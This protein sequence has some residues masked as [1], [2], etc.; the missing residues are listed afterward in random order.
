MGAAAAVENEDSDQ[1]GEERKLLLDP[2]ILPKP[3]VE[4]NPTLTA[5]LQLTQMSRPCSP[6]LPRQLAT[7]LMCLP[8]TPRAR[9]STR[10]DRASSVPARPCS[11]AG[12]PIGRS[13]HR[14]H[15]SPAS[16]TKWWPASQI[17]RRAAS[18][19]VYFLRSV[20]TSKSEDGPE[21]A[22]TDRHWPSSSG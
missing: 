16:P 5:Y 19:S 6:S 20:W 9:S 22:R 21:E 15:L 12:L 7:S 2:G 3:P 14:C 13:C 17:S 18:A 11:A 1:D 8:Q 10:M 4:P